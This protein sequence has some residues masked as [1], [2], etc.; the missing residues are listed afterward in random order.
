MKQAASR[1]ALAALA[2]CTLCGAATA[3]SATLPGTSV[4]LR[5]GGARLPRTE[6]PLAPRLEVSHAAA[7]PCRTNR[8]AD[9]DRR[10]MWPALP[11][12]ASQ[13][14]PT[15]CRRLGRSRESQLE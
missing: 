4:T 6:R 5:K 10:R 13:T 2:V 9:L 12:I 14:G 3:R 11:G 7:S 1:F 15:T 8:H